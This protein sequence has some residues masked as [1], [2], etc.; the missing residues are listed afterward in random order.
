M[1][2]ESRDMKE[3]LS[4]LRELRT[5]LCTKEKTWT[6]A[7][8]VRDWLF[9]ELS[10]IKSVCDRDDSTKDEVAREIERLVSDLNIK[11]DKDDK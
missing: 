11:G 10:R 5:K 3:R 6:E 4:K 9:S 8:K 2:Q 1:S 7:F